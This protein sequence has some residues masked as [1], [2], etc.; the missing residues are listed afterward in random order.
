MKLAEAVPVIPFFYFR[1]IHP[2]PCALLSHFFFRKSKIFSQILRRD[3][4]IFVKNVDRRVLAVFFDREDPCH[5]GQIH[6]FRAFEK[7][8]EKIQIF[9]LFFFLV[10]GHSEYTVPFINDENKAFSGF[11][12][13]L[14]QQCFQPAVCRK[15]LKIR[16]F[17][18]QIGNDLFFDL[19][20]KCIEIPFFFQKALDVKADDTVPVQVR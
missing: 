16:K 9:L 20:D 15:I 10:F 2:V 17:P 14:F 7:S 8:P 18:G 12:K 5:I 11:R 19:I 4:G 3:H 6:I 1:I 13:D